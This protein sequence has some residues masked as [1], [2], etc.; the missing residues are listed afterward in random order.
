MT[1]T[2]APDQSERHGFLERSDRSELICSAL[3]DWLR[4]VG[5]W[6]KLSCFLFPLHFYVLW[7][8]PQTFF[9]KFILPHWRLVTIATICAQ[10]QFFFLLL[11]TLWRRHKTFQSTQRYCCQRYLMLSEPPWCCLRYLLHVLKTTLRPITESPC[12]CSLCSAFSSNDYI[13]VRQC[14]FT[15]IETPMFK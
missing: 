10:I 8:I 11:L 7:V 14:S 15:E 12:R 1:N 9:L 4:F 3:L 13:I 5:F 2:V 6:G